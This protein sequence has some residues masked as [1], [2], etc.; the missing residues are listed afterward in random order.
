M[1]VCD[2][3]G[4]CRFQAVNS[5]P[6]HRSTRCGQSTDTAGPQTCQGG[7]VVVVA[8]SLCQLLALLYPRC[9]DLTDCLKAARANG[10]V[11]VRHTHAH[12]H[13]CT[14]KLVRVPAAVLFLTVQLCFCCCSN[15]HW[16]CGVVNAVCPF[17]AATSSS[18]RFI[19][20]VP[21]TPCV[22]SP[23]RKDVIHALRYLYFARSIL[24]TQAITDYGAANDEWKVTRLGGT[25]RERREKD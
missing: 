20:C 2:R 5:V 14:H 13:T 1:N 4:R 6:P 7:F 15:E 9:F 17:H 12:T 22:S 25:E 24:L 8:E 23:C 18:T 3:N 21:L 16:S 19:C 10:S 11:A